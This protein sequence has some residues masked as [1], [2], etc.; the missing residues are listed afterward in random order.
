MNKTNKIIR[1][2]LF[3]YVTFYMAS[4]F[5]PLPNAKEISSFLMFLILG[6]SL[7]SIRS[8]SRN[9]CLAFFLIGLSIFLFTGAPW[10]K[11]FFSIGE[12]GGLL[13]LFVLIPIMAMPFF[14]DDYQGELGN[15]TRRY[16]S[17]VVPFL[18]FILLSCHFLALMV[19]AGCFVILYHLFVKQAKEYSCTPL[20]HIALLQ[21]YMSA[22]FWGPV[23]PPAS[24]IPNRLGLSWLDVMPIGVIFSS[25]MLLGAGICLWR[26]VENNPQLYPRFLPDKS[27]SVDWQRVRTLGLLAAALV[28]GIV[29]VNYMTRW[30]MFIIVPLTS[31]PF[32][33]FT[34]LIQNKMD[35]LKSGA[36]AY[37]KEGIVST[38]A[39]FCLFIVAGFLGA[40]IEYSN[41]GEFVVQFLPE[42]FFQYPALVAL[43]IIAFLMITSFI[44]VH[45]IVSAPSLALALSAEHIGLN[46]LSF[47]LTLLSGWVLGLTVSPF[48]SGIMLL[49]ALAQKTPWEIGP[50]A[51][52]KFAAGMAVVF[53][54]AVSLLHSMTS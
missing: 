39:E 20:F 4:F 14:Y 1:G 25:L 32:A 30:S 21:G 47:S 19:F 5:F 2:L 9:V 36:V 42:A 23:W 8:F 35:K 26:T 22:G 45:P 18:L 7:P 43:S 17:S 49:A 28:I 33:F 41:A 46:Q 51:N 52:W 48:S 40:A 34:A 29:L 3:C 10:Q 53:S 37:Y 44:G 31:V 12:N 24:I 16:T 50:F 6:F 13:A 11:I 38:K 27:V 54:L 15:I